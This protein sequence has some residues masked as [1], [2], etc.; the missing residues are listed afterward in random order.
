MSFSI[1][2]EKESKLS[3]L[4]AEIIREQGKFIITIYQKPTVSGV[5]T[6]YQSFL[7]AVYK[8]SMVYTLV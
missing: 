2:T 1:K 8:F 6:N 7:P 3:F 5:Y 4:D